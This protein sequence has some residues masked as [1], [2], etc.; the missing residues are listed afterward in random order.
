MIREEVFDMVTIDCEYDRL[1]DLQ[2]DEQF[3]LKLW[4]L[5]I[6]PTE[7]PDTA[8]VTPRSL[9]GA[10]AVLRLMQEPERRPCTGQI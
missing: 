9:R 4:D 6:T 1:R 10:L 5:E 2:Q 8:K 3:D 7:H